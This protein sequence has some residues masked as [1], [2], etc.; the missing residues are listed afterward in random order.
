M[1][2]VL[3]NRSCRNTSFGSCPCQKSDL[4]AARSASQ[5]VVLV[6]IQAVLQVVAQ[7]TDEPRVQYA[8]GLSADVSVRD[9]KGMRDSSRLLSVR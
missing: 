6:L 2:Y 7:W 8:L 4:W 9:F 3:L 1:T 5:S